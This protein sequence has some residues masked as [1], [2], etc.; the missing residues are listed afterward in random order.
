LREH[1]GQLYAI[2]P[3]VLQP[4]LRSKIRA[5]VAEIDRIMGAVRFHVRHCAVAS[6][7]FAVEVCIALFV[8]DAFVRPYLGDV[9][10]MP[11]MYCAIATLFDVR[12]W[13]LGLE[14][15]AVAYGVEF[16]QAGGLVF[17]LGLEHNVWARTILGSA[18][19]NWDLVAYTVGALL[20]VCVHLTLR[21]RWPAPRET[22]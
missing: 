18:Y 21:R 6:G 12:P 15:L 19:S 11:L 4:D 10:V 16:A 2:V 3:A 9:L 14:T 20:T 17:W 5:T 1:H 7:V 22:F 13:V 8:D